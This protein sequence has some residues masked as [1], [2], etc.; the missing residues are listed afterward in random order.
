MITVIQTLAGA[1]DYNGTA[2]FGGLIDFDVVWPTADDD[3]GVYYII[4]NI[5]LRGGGTYDVDC[6]IQFPGGAA[7][8][9]LTIRNE[10]GLTGFTN[11]GCRI[12]VPNATVQGVGASPTVDPWQLTLITTG[13]TT[14]ASFIVSFSTEN[15]R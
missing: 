14:D 3:R 9:R 12:V 10:T 8:E 4:E 7:T 5:E 2:P 6:F 1:V 15:K 11:L 13:K